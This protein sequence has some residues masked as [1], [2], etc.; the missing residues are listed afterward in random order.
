MGSHKSGQERLEQ[1]ERCPC[2]HRVL[3]HV[4]VDN[5]DLPL[6]ELEGRFRKQAQYRHECHLVAIEVEA[7]TKIRKS[8][9]ERYG[10]MRGDYDAGELSTLLESRSRSPSVART[11]DGTARVSGV[12]GSNLWVSHLSNSD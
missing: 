3:G 7:N 8:L 2:A 4:L 12:E 1:L 10:P 11:L 5:S 6:L 9:I